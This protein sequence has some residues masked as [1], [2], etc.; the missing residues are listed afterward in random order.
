MIG[1]VLILRNTFLATMSL[2]SAAV[3]GRQVVI[4]LQ[5]GSDLSN[6]AIPRQMLVLVG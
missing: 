2:P 5:L 6:G 3:R 4:R 1:L